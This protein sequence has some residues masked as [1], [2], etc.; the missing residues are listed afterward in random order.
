MKTQR[1]HPVGAVRRTA[2]LLTGTVVVLGGSFALAGPASAEPSEGWPPSDPVRPLHAI[3]VLGGIP[4]ALTLI[5][6][7]LLYL[8][9]MVRGERVAPGTT[10]VSNQWIGGPR[11]AA[12][13]L[14]GPDTEESMAGGAGARW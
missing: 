4:I 8:P 11:R 3:L 9:A 14:A 5:I 7:A 6:A 2:A 12:G 10:P 13:E 1:P